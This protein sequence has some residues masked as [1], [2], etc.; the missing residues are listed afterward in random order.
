MSGQCLQI[1]TSRGGSVGW[2][3]GGGRK[4]GRW[5]W[6]LTGGR[7]MAVGAGEGWEVGG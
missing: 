3:E 6:E 4:G 5:R 1:L 7:T 2:L